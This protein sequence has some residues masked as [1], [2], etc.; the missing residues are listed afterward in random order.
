MMTNLKKSKKGFTLVELIVVI[1]ILAIIAAVAI[2]TTIAYIGSSERGTAYSNAGTVLRQVQN[3]ANDLRNLTIGTADGESS[4]VLV[5][6]LTKTMANPAETVDK[7]EVREDG[8]IIVYTT[9]PHD[10]DSDYTTTVVTT[11]NVVATGE[12]GVKM[13]AAGGDTVYAT[14]YWTGSVWS[15]TEA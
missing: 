3:N 7:V 13:T 15:V 14:A 12:A 11:D 10:D 9:V 1:A 2:P 6:I 5:D 4:D 8:T